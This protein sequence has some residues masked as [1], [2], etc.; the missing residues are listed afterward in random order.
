MAKQVTCRDGGYDCDFM[1]RSE[2][3][4]QLIQM[5]QQ[6]AKETHDSELSRSDVQGLVKNV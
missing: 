1:I 3:E 6:H 2:D 4:D 5:V